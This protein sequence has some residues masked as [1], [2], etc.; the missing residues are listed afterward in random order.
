MDSRTCIEVIGKEIDDAYMAELK[1]QIIH[2]EI[3]KEVADE[4]QD[5]LYA[6]PWNRKYSGQTSP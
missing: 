5:R 1:K 2:P 4:T 3:I 6:L